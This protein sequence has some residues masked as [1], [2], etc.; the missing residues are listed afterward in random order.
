MTYLVKT[1]RPTVM[2]VYN[3][4]GTQNVTSGDKIEF[5]TKTT[6][7]SDSVSISSAGVI[8]LSASRSYYISCNI[9]VNRSSTTADFG[10]DWYN[11]TTNTL[12]TQSE[13][14][15][16]ARY[17]PTG[18]TYKNGNLIGQLVLE[19][20]TFDVS[21]RASNITASTGIL[22]NFYL[23]IIEIDT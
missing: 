3:A 18:S 20:P 6:T 19:N 16:S 21:L 5:P 14:A 13:G 22:E 4:D 11:D 7:G 8:S 2:I 17:L 23:F 10:A 12:L 15:F 9:A 1:P